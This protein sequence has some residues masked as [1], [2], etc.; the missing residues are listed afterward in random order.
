VAV[1]VAFAITVVL[2]P[3][4]ARVARRVGI[5]DHPGPLKVHAEPVPYLGGIAVYA[6]LAAPIAFQHPALLV[7][8]LLATA[9]GLAD[10][11]VR[12][13]PGVR[14]GCEAIV[15]V[16]VAWLVPTRGLL[17]AVAAFV[18]VLVLL[19]ALNLLDGLDGLA[20][21]VG[22]VAA[23]GFAIL[24]PGDGRVIALGLAGALGGILVWNRP[25][26]RIFLG[27]AGSYLVGTTLAMLLAE[28]IAPGRPVAHGASA[29]L[30]VGVPVA[31]TAVAILRR[32]RAHTAL[33]QGDRGH[34]YDQLV[35]RGWDPR[36]TTAACI[37][38]QAVLVAAG[39]AISALSAAAAVA[40][41]AFVI[42]AVGG[43][44]IVMFTSPR[45]WSP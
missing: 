28:S 15:G 36:T 34:V 23:V 20:S 29:L 27:D 38:A 31:D 25:P 42:V 12:L 3:V 30:F 10:D 9:L 37:G 24:L 19:N 41:T 4:M 6:G 17:G 18:F 21:G 5:V 1:I 16:T 33:F 7:P 14:L 44:A 11:A 35:D 45:A 43:T 40:L 2:A 26:A 8:L 22:L 32:L 39:L 13:T